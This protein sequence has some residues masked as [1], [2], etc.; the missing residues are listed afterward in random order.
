MKK[1]LKKTLIL[2]TLVS[3]STQ[4]NVNGAAVI[5]NLESAPG[6]YIV[7]GNNEFRINFSIDQP[8]L[9][10]QL[11]RIQT[12]VGKQGSISEPLLLTAYASNGMVSQDSYVESNFNNGTLDVEELDLSTPLNLQSGTTY[13]LIFSAPTLSNG[14]W[15]KF[16]DVGSLTFYDPQTKQTIT[17]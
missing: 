16:A 17:D 4:L 14:Q 10:I 1:Y 11:T 7:G 5:G 2:I 13:S 8:N 9:N 6:T 12:E 15:Y 3:V